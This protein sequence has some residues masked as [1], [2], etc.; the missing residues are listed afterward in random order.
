MGSWLVLV[1]SSHGEKQPTPK[2]GQDLLK[3]FYSNCFLART[4]TTKFVNVD[5]EEICSYNFDK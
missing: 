2:S 5:K 1:V 4:R 3:H